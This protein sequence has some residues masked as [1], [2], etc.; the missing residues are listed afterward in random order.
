MSQLPLSMAMETGTTREGSGLFTSTLCFSST[1]T[2][3]RQ[4]SFAAYISGVRPPRSI[5]LARLSEVA[6]RW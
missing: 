1:S 5:D 3:S 6:T 4:F 2:H